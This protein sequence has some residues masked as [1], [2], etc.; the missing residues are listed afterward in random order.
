[1]V[2]GVRRSPRRSRHRRRWR[3]L[4][5]LSRLHQASPSLDAVAGFGMVL[6]P[7]DGAAQAVEALPHDELRVYLARG[8]GDH[9]P[10][11][12]ATAGHTGPHVMRQSDTATSR[13]RNIGIFMGTRPEAIK[14]AP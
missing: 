4:R 2:Q 1:M 9:C 5:R 7:P 14:L 13:A 10:P 12:W 8:P 11:T 6:A 3:Q